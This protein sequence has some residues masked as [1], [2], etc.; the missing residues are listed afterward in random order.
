MSN[1]KP[2][3]A[4][5]AGAAQAGAGGQQQQQHQ[6]YKAIVKSIVSGDS[7]ILRS[8]QAGKDG[9][10]LEKQVMLAHIT[11]PRLGRRLNPQS[12]DS[13]IEPDQ[14]SS[15]FQTLVFVA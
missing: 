8:L 4:Q 5:A 1:Q 14:V 3:T 2:T 6:L 9:K 10:I 13:V 15:L 7:V 11:A 12:Q